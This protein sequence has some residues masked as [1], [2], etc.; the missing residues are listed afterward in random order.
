MTPQIEAATQQIEEIL[1]QAP[2]LITYGDLGKELDPEQP[3]YSSR[4]R[5][6]LR[7]ITES[8]ALAGRP[9][10]TSLVVNKRTRIP[11][12]T[13]FEQTRQAGREVPES[14]PGMRAFA[15]SE[16]QKVFAARGRRN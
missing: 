3:A 12:G 4:M 16:Q 2:G 5:A 15:E 7:A 13:F 6:A 8:D 11:G 10:R 14:K 9:I 1:A